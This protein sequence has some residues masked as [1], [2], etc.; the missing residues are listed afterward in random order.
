MIWFSS[1]QHLWHANILKYNPNRA[2]HSVEEMNEA[3][4]YNWNERVAPTDTIYCLGDFSFA[5]R[6]V[7]LYS[8]RL[9]GIKKLVPGNHDPVHPYN[10]HAKK[11]VKAGQP[12]QWKLFYEKH[13][14]EV[15]PLTSQ[16]DIPG[17]AVVNL[18]HMPY[19]NQDSRYVDY[20]PKDDGRWLLH[21]HT[22]SLERQRGRMIH[23]GVDAWDCRPVSVDEIAEIIKKGT[24]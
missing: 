16:F 17:V 7:E 24:P 9:N 11:A 20:M 14:W 2:Y 18:N 3:I 5:G 10:K 8:A 15:L 13:G 23:V 21:G 6:S 12:D 22:H 4:I 19:D 1:D